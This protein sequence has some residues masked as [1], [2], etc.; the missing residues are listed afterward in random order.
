LTAVF[1]ALGLGILIGASLLDEGKL[2]ESQEKLIAGLEKRFDMLQSERDL[3]EKENAVLISQ[4]NDHKA[5]L[6]A[7]ELPL[8]EGALAGR[9]VSV[10]YADDGWRE[11]WQEPLKGLME[12]AGAVVVGS[13]LISG[14]AVEEHAALQSGHPGGLSHGQSFI[15]NLQALADGTKGLL[16]EGTEQ[17][18]DS[19]VDIVLLV[20]SGGDSTA[21]WEKQLAAQAKDAGMGIAVIG[22][23]EMENHLNELA[24][25]GVL[26]LDNLDDAAGRIALV[27]GLS[28]KKTGYYGVGRHAKAPWTAIDSLENHR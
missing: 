2:I 23:A 15:L 3:L 24:K 10:V 26:A 13:K 1:L 14:L 6:A 28:S 9:R 8:I 7:L 19:S 11:N 18:P 16:G 12:K 21:D 5:L 27:L 25:I 4:I 22:T 17:T 20:G